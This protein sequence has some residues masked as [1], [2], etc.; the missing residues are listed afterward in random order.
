MAVFLTAK[1]SQPLLTLNDLTSGFNNLSYK[2]I[3]NIY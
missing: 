3:W 1:L 2:S